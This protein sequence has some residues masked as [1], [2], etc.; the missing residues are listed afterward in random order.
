VKNKQQKQQKLQKPKKPSTNNDTNELT[1]LEHI[2]E[3]RSR[4][5]W[6]V[7]TIILASAAGFQF[8]DQLIS[9]V[10]DPLH[11]QKLVY[12]TPGGGFGFIFTLA[13]YFGVLMAIPVIVYHVYRFLQPLLSKTSKKLVAMFMLLSCLLAA[14]GAAFGY[15]VTIPAA[16]DFL[17]TFAGDAVI[18]N[19]TAE[20]YLNFVVAYILGLALLFQLPLLLFLFDHVRPFP[21]GSLL[22]SQRY[23]IIGSTVI[24]A[25]IT[26]TP[27]AFNMAIVAVPIVVIYQLG[28][29]AVA[30]RHRVLRR[31]KNK[32]QRALA[33]A[34]VPAEAQPLTELLKETEDKHD[35]N[36][37]G[38]ESEEQ[39]VDAQNSHIQAAEREPTAMS[40]AAQSTRSIQ[41]IDGVVRTR[42]PQPVVVPLRVVAAQRLAESR[43]QYQRPVRSVDGLSM[44][45]YSTNS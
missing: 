19:L 14:G 8:K 39:F 1:F 13:I 22:S 29:I 17:A 27:D 4:L 44:L 30:I 43:S 35:E 5:F 28:V 23:V 9:V 36:T 18:P 3:L 20:S 6:I 24:A 32:V 34:A 25:I 37:P 15:F 12:L 42:G 38:K 26:P 21:P 45:G 16:L 33:T 11:G 31:A 7:A 41:T 10:M 2:Y 40:R